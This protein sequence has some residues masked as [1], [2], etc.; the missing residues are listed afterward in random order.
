M[1]TMTVASKLL[2]QKNRNLPIEIT[3]AF[4]KTAYQGGR[5]LLSWIKQDMKQ[6]KT[7]RV[8]KS[9][10]GVK[11]KYKQAK[12]ITASAPSETPAIRT[13]NFRKSV[14]FAVIG[15]TKLEWGS[16]KG[17]ATE[18]ASALEFGTQKMQAREPLQRSMK[19][20]DGAIKAMSIANIKKTIFKNA[21]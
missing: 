2:L 19:A 11:G 14:D 12:F 16:G 21:G 5:I 1:I 3:N 7:G 17:S 10:F 13:G 4:R 8:Y 6:P 20:N 9:Y 15:N 18:Y